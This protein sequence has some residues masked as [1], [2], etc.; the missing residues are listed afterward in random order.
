MLFLILCLVHCG[1]IRQTASIL[2]M[3]EDCLRTGDKAKVRF[4]F[5]KYPEYLRPGQ[6]LVFREGRTK[7]VGNV[8]FVPPPSG[9]VG[10]RQSQK[11]QKLNPQAQGQV[12][13]VKTSSFLTNFSTYYT[14]LFFITEHGRK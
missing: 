2:S 7:A 13:K 9:Q 4:R 5:I 3:S 14:Y 6:R 1:S 11:P 12:I 8:L 10:V